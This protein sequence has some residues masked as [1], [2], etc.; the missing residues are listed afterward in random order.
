MQIQN[1]IKLVEVANTQLAEIKTIILQ[2]SNNYRMQTVRYIFSILQDLWN[3]IQGNMK[4]QAHH[5]QM[6]LADEF[7]SCKG[8]GN[9]YTDEHIKE[10]QSTYKQEG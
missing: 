6:F 2:A 3:I 7:D 9:I 8:K 1:I 10:I 5:I 4:N